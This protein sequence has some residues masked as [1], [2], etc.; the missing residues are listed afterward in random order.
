MSG[1]AA[2]FPLPALRDRL[3]AA[4][5]VALAFSISVS[6]ALLVALLLVVPW[7]RARRLW[8]ATAPLRHHPLTSPLAVFAALTLLSALLSGDP[9]GSL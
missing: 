6:Q 3:L 9:G 1:V 2:T 7:T 4:F 8:L 5:F